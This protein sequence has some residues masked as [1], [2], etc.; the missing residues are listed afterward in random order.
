MSIDFIKARLEN[1]NILLLL[2]NNKLNFK[3]EYS[4]STSEINTTKY[5]AELHFCTITVYES[6][7]VMFNGS[8]HK[9]YNSIQGIKA[10]NYKCKKDTYKGFNGNIFYLDEIIYIRGY[11]CELLSL[12][13]KDIVF[14]NI[15]FGINC[16]VK[17]NPSIFINSLLYQQNKKFEFRYNGNYA[18]VRHG[19]YKIKIYNKSY[20][21]RMAENTLRVE[22][23]INKSIELKKIGIRTFA[24]IKPDTIKK[25][26]GLL[27]KKFDEV[28]YFDPTTKKKDLKPRD[29]I[30]LKLFRDVRYWLEDLEPNRRYLPLKKLRH[31]IS[32]HS[33]NLH[34]QIRSEIIKKCVIINR[35]QQSI[36]CVMI[37]SSNIELNITHDTHR[38]CPIT[39][40]DIS[41]QKADSFR[42]S[43]TG[44]KHLEKHAP[45]RYEKLKDIFLTGHNN[46]YENSVYCRISK[47]I[48]NKFYNNRSNFNGNQLRLF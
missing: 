14:E 31:F 22:L 28:I 26:K 24:D 48:R 5:K 27:L 46:V 43:N 45:K 12:T 30:K 41:M 8:I 35:P 6:G 44:L 47:Q 25:A 39:R 34:A 40:E 37:N 11:L 15:E 4:R 13:A 36:K 32:E 20:Q 17:F 18:E 10:P 19:R 42:L 1:I 16:D 33:D 23:Q 2:E 7:R 9:M 3:S 21:Y 38:I 29:K